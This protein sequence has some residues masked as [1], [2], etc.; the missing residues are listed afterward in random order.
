MIIIYTLDIIISNVVNEQ[1]V[2]KLS[3]NC[4]QNGKT[5]LKQNA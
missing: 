3:S 4:R 2:V 5:A 1:I